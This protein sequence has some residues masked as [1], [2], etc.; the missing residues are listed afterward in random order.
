MCSLSLLL[1]LLL[2]LMQLLVLLL[3]QVTGAAIDTA[4]TG[5]SIDA[6]TSATALTTAKHFGVRND[7]KLLSHYSHS[8]FDHVRN[9]SGVSR[10]WMIHALRDETNI[11]RKHQLCFQ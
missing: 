1:L 3:V 7:R 4:A 6:S 11:L 9:S 2:L 5:A 10:Q 8:A